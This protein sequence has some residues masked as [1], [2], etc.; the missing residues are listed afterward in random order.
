MFKTNSYFDDKVISIAFENQEG[1]AT[2]GVMAPGEYTF[3]TT[4]VE[5]MT[6]VSGEMHVQLPGSDDWKN[7]KP[8][9]TFKVEAEKSFN[10]KVTTDTSYRCIYK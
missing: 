3:G 5:F 7:Y 6:V 8:F 9:E 10:V 2:V 4:S 1:K